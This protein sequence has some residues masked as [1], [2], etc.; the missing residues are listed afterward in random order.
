MKT[1]GSE[2]QRPR[3]SKN[4]GCSGLYDPYSELFTSTASLK[5]AN[6]VTKP[7]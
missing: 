6:A 3:S 5:L 1:L 7:P 4:V 2:L